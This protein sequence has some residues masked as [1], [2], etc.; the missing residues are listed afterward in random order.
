MSQTAP[1]K[2]PQDR[3]H[4]FLI[5]TYIAWRT[6][7]PFAIAL[8]VVLTALLLERVLRLFDMLAMTGGPLDV[9]LELAASLVPFYLGLALPAAFFLAVFLTVA[10]MGD[11]N[12]LDALLASGVSI[13][14]LSRPFFALSIVLMFL[15]LPL[16]GFIQPYTRYAFHAIMYAAQNA[17]WDAHVEPAAFVNVTKN[18]A[19]TADE[20]DL[21]GQELRGIFIRRKTK[22][23]EEITTAS[24]GRL[25]LAPDGKSLD[26]FLKKGQTVE[27]H[28]GKPPYVV[29][30]SNF[31]SN[32]R[33]PSDVPP[34]RARGDSERELTLIELRSRLSDKVSVVPHRRLRS[35]FHA[36]IARTLSLPLIPFLAIPLAMASKRRRRTSGIIVSALLM[37]SYHH[38]LQLGESLADTGA[39]PAI[40]AIWIPFGLFAALCFWLFHSSRKRLG[41]NPVSRLVDWTE[42]G[43]AQVAGLVSRFRKGK[44]A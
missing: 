20:V 44:P 23:G 40:P 19:V 26:L 43:M 10:R 27:D 29:G 15:T 14:R 11:E 12:E 18:I 17:G 33:F 36:R 34:F 39:L 21:T 5:D 22:D 6:L 4:I 2:A 38:I 8:G 35:E 1:I 25:Q 42:G 41:D 37:V 32:F 31:K 13:T 16:F 9:V 3:A 24:E 30:F 28:A 7:R